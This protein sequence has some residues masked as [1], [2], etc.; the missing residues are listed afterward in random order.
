M[1]PVAAID[2]F[3]CGGGKGAIPGVVVVE[4]PAAGE[5]TDGGA[6]EEEEAGFLQANS[7][8]ICLRAQFEHCGGRSSH[9]LE[10]NITV[11]K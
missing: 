3:N 7:H 6:M 5:V 2:P 9:Y 1:A 11:N 4:W 10:G 8:S